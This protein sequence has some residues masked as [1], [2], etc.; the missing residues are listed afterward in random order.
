MSKQLPPQPHLDSLKKQA[1]QLLNGYRAAEPEAL[2]RVGDMQSELPPSAQEAFSLRQ[3]QQVIARE[4][5]FSSW[6]QLAAFVGQPIDERR[7]KSAYLEYF[8]RMA[9]K[10]MDDL[11][12]ENKTYVLDRIQQALP[13]YAGCTRQEVGEALS[14]QEAQLVVARLYEC[15]SWEAFA[16]TV[17]QYKHSDG[18]LMDG[19]QLRGLEALHGEFASALAANFS[20]NAAAAQR[21]DVGMAFVDQTTYGEFVRSIAGPT[22]GFVVEMDGLNGPI[23]GDIALPVAR[24][25]LGSGLED[26]SLAA[27]EMQRMQR[28]AE[29]IARDVK[30]AWIPFIDVAVR[31]VQMHTDPRA[32]RAVPLHE[33]VGLLA[34]EA[35]GTGPE[36]PFCGLVSLCY[37][38]SLLEAFLPN[39]SELA[40]NRAT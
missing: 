6:Q 4:Y 10:L 26:S 32:P 31:T 27:G 23:V 34:F 8:V 39:L 35:N 1:R 28:I 12:D 9:I 36:A 20:S 19:Q 16:A 2:Q 40:E 25:L 14:L 30:N 21:V 17:K 13:Q 7:D 18:P 24:G 37:P 33:I 3:A 15:D 38:A 11:G 5:G 22:C 29:H